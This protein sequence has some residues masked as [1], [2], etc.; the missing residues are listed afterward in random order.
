MKTTSC[1]SC[2]G[3]VSKTAEACPHCGHKFE[4]RIPLSAKIL[5]LVFL[6]LTLFL[7]IGVVLMP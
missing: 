6:G 7:M 5:V 4:S 2:A 3:L 1:P